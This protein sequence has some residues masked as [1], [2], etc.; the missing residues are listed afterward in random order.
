MNNLAHSDLSWFKPLL[1]GNSP[2]S[3]GVVLM[4]KKCYNRVS[5]VLERF[6]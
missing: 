6:T 2:T 4:K 1:G 5:R 3:N